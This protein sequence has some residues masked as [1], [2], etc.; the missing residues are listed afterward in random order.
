MNNQIIPYQGKKPILFVKVPEDAH[1]FVVNH[2]ERGGILV[3]SS[4]IEDGVNGGNIINL[5][6]GEWI[7][8][9]FTN[10][11]TEEQWKEIVSGIRWFPVCG[12]GTGQVTPFASESGRSLIRSLDIFEVNPYGDL[13][14]TQDEFLNPETNEP[15]ID[16]FES[17][18]RE[19][20]EAEKT[21]G[22]WLA[23]IQ[24]II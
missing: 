15:C 12:G 16:E 23:L 10:E 2:L 5:P 18:K 4:E 20:Q 19:W 21:T 14:P 3:Y 6:P 13:E 22:K 24:K 11:L 8:L 7:P 9:G 17:Y 1:T